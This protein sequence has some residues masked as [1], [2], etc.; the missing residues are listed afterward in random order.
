MASLEVFQDMM[1]RREDT[2]LKAF[3]GLEGGVVAAGSTCGVVSGGAMGLALSHYDEIADKGIPAQ[4]ALLSLTGEYVRWFEDRF[5][6]SL[7]RE[8]TG[9]DFYSAWGQFRYFAPGDRVSKCLWHI[10][11]AARHLHPCLQEKLPITEMESGG[12][13]NKPMHCAEAVLKGI[14]ER[15][16]VGDD[17]LEDLSFVFDGGVGLQGG[18]CGALAGAVMGLNVSIGM[19]VRDMSYFRILKTFTVGH[20]NLLTDKPLGKPEPFSMGSEVVKE[21]TEAGGSMECRD[22]TGRAFEDWPAFQGYISSSDKCLGLI[23]LATNQGSEAI[24]KYLQG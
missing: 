19:N 15:T 6:S 22:I 18:V 20:I 3:T 9:A 10:R 17:L 8:R 23:E 12:S 13:A 16:G 4:S 11:G 7:C 2:L 5:G 24:K 14:R 21:F 1:G